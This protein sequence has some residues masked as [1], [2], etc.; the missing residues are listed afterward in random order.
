[1]TK[2]T[3]IAIGIGAAVVVL[4]AAGYA[5]QRRKPQGIQVRTAKAERNNLAS[6]VTANGT[7]EARTKVDLS[8][9]IMGQITR[10][11]V[12]EGDFV[13]KGDLLLVIDQ[14]RYASAVDSSRSALES[15]ESEL[16]RVR[17]VA[18]QAKRDL[19]RA[20]AQYRDEILA[21]ADFDRTKSYYEQSVAAVQRAERQVTQARADLASSRDALD[22]TE[23]R[24]PMDGVVTRRS[25]E[26]GE[27]VV[28]GTMN[29][30]GTVLMTISDMSAVEAVLEVDQ[31]D[32]PLLSLGQPAAVL[33]D[34]FPGKPFPGVVSE[35]GSSPIRGTTSLGQV[36]TGTDYEVKVLLTSHPA[37]I[38]P[39]L[40]VTADITTDTRERV[41]T[42][43]IGA[44]VLRSEDEKK[45][46]AG[47]PEEEAERRR[48]DGE[49]ATVASRARDVEGVYVVR[50]GKAVFRP[51]STGIKG[52][53][54][55]EVVRGL[56]EKDEVIVGPFKALRELKPDAKVVVD[57]TEHAEQE[58]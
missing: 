36:A 9:N 45:G 40:T 29:N 54:D 8:A 22:K 13:K 38:R 16:A 30:P 11:N 3:K 25:V 10:L 4:A 17:E 55:L 18:A 20:T 32:V 12:R 5:I 50:D 28:T 34:A 56:D 57:N 33:V 7:I 23:I 35:I 6:L 14:V 37:G 41:L 51:V 47:K 58:K 44:L 39:G 1:M 21:A 53:L 19:D 48:T 46:G 27:V 31:T 15:I 49:I 26:Q 42:V 52:E 2:R 43:P 24:A